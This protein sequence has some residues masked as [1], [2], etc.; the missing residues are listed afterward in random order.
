MSTGLAIAGFFLA[1]ITAGV[2][3]ASAVTAHNETRGKINEIL[4]RLPAGAAAATAADAADAT[5][6]AATASAVDAGD[7]TAGAATASA[8]TVSIAAIGKPREE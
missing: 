2:L 5:G 3:L 6:A 1:V 4:K 8:A 7:A